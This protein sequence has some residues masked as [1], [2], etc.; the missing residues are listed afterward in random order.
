MFKNLMEMLAERIYPGELYCLCC[1]KA[2]DW[3]RPYGLCDNCMTNMKWATGRICKKCGK[4]L[5]ENNPEDI[6]YNCRA[7]AHK[8]NRGYTCTEYGEIGRAMV[9]ALKYD[10]KPAIARSI[11][12][13]MADRML[14]EFTKEELAARYNL[15]VPV[16]VAA[17]R[18][19]TRGYNQAALIAEF[20]AEKTGL[21]YSGEVLKRCNETAKLK[22]LTPAERRMSL[23]DSFALIAGSAA[24]PNPVIGASCLIIDD[25][26]TT[27][28][29]ADEIAGVLYNNGATNV[30]FLSFAS[31]ADV[32]KS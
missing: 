8:F 12:E 30:D 6:C 32:I 26:M 16:P 9:Y 11:G 15:L 1:G 31:G 21:P 19:A 29:T 22:G 5:S 4:L 28:A 14:S 10:E 18:L 23:H 3:S 17:E 7:I 2:I 24:R 27:G 20:F 13:I 25:I